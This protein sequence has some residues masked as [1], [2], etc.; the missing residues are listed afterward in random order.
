MTSRGEVSPEPGRSRFA[1]LTSVSYQ[2]AGS[3]LKMSLA[4][5]KKPARSTAGAAA[6]AS[7]SEPKAKKARKA[8]GG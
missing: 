6:P 3:A 5:A 2:Y 4:E 1:G 7:E 8:A